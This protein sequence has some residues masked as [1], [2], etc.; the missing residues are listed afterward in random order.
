MYRRRD[1]GPGDFVF[2]ETVAAVFPD[3]IQR[4]VPGYPAIVNMIE[5]LAARYAQPGS[6]LLDLGC[7]LGASTVALASGAAGR[8]CTVVGVD[9][10]AAMLDRARALCVAAHPEITW[11]CADVRDFAIADASVVVLNFT[12]Q[13]VP[14]ADRAALLARIRAGLRP[15]GILILSEKIAGEDAGADALLN[16]MH[17]AFKRANGY[18]DLEISRKRSALE[19]VLVPETIATHRARLQQAGFTRSDLWFQCFNFASMVA[20]R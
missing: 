8:D 18:S 12:L 19:N 16:D 1:A 15:D 14:V 10:A 6:L 20:A 9:N 11:Q 5:L 13:F 3:M 7:S 4:S 2:D 17:H